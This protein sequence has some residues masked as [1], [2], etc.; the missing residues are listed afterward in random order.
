MKNLYFSALVSCSLLAGTMTYGQPDAPPQPG[1]TGAVRQG[2]PVYLT[3]YMENKLVIIRWRVFNEAFTDHYIVE[4]S[5]DNVNFEPLHEIVAQGGG[6]G[7]YSY[8]DGDSYPSSEVNY[9]RLKIVDEDGNAVYSSVVE[10]DRLGRKPPVLKP[11]VLHMG[12]TLN[13]TDS[14]YSQPLMINFF[15]QGGVRVGSFMV[16]STSFDIPVGNWNK[17]IYFYRISDATH[18]LI[19]AGKIMVL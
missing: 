17:G 9:Y 11:T 6:D 13:V 7:D 5:T 15:N 2:S 14:Y 10:T 3:S 18:P 4:R 12:G 8:Q 1:E 19:D 16:N